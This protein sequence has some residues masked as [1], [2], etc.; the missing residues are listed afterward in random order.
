MSEWLPP[1][2]APGPRRAK[3]WT[4]MCTSLTSKGNRR[5]P[6]RGGTPTYGLWLLPFLALVVNLLGIGSA[7]CPTTRVACTKG[8]HGREYHGEYYDYLRDG[9]LGPPRGDAG[10]PPVLPTSPS[11]PVDISAQPRAAFS[12]SG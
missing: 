2:S 9:H 5:P 1:P 6:A 10:G 11:L 4:W 8:Y 3:R 7:A 12:L